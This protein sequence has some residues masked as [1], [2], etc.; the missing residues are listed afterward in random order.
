MP[1]KLVLIGSGELCLGIMKG[2]QA[3]PHSVLGVMPWESLM[4]VSVSGRMMRRA[5]RVLAPS[6]LDF[7]AARGWHQLTPCSANSADFAQQ[8]NALD[9]DILL[10]AGWGEILKTQALTLPRFMTLNCHPSYLPYHRGADPVHSVL[11]AG[12]SSTGL[13]FHQLIEAIDAGPLVLQSRILVAQDDD[14]DSLTRKLSLRA[15][16]TVAEALELAAAGGPFTAQDEA[17]AQYVSRPNP[18]DR[19]LNWADPAAAIHNIVRA[20]NHQRR[21]LTWHA[22]R[23]LH[24]RRSRLQPLHRPS[25]EPGK[26]LFKSGAQVLMAT[27]TP[28]MGLWLEGASPAGAS[29]AAPMAGRL[30]CL[31]RVQVG[32]RFESTAPIKS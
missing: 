21:P 11:R 10:V 29:G 8:V 1:L 15:F 14:Y 17:I 19:V 25:A 32:D 2:L 22:G 16:E 3:T 28:D 23:A 5:K 18:T 9:P 6:N 31:H 27:G 20:S 30:Y 24:L 26:V 12:E 4:Q 7:I 13:S